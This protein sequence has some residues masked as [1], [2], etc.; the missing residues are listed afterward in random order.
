MSARPTLP[1]VLWLMAIGTFAIGT[2]AFVVA[3]VLPEIARDLDVSTAAA[4]QTITLFSLT[5]A[6]F[7]P[8]SATLTGSL[9]RRTV[10]RLALVL[11]ILGNVLSA[12]A[13]S[14]GWLLAGRVVAALG[15]ASFTPQASAAAS[16]LVEEKVRGRALGVVIGGLTVATA[17]GV[18]LGTFLG[19]A[20][21]WRATLVAVAVLGAVALAGGFALPRLEPAG[22]HTLGERLGA[23]RSLPVLATLL[24]TLL[25]VMSEHVLYAYIGPVLEP[26]TGGDGAKLSLLLLVFGI[27]AVAGNAVAGRATDQYGP[28][29][30]LLLALGGMAVDLALTPLWAQSFPTAAVALFVW[31]ATGW[32]YLVPQQHRLLE[33]SAANGPFTVALNSSALY[34]GIGVAGAAGGAVVSGAGA[35]WLPLPAALLGAAAVVLAVLTYRS[36]VSPVPVPE[37]QKA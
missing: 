9:S 32:M 12:V 8:V 24:V 7:A 5:Y 18:P 1:P 26:A 27:G 2:D 15:A 21:G 10:L 14:Y 4:G 36:R 11:F 17:L 31:G 33:L 37:T 20:F 23:L 6:V 3:G 22:R 30:V 13:A 25:G 35:D 16:A 28:R 19:D 34:L 29:P